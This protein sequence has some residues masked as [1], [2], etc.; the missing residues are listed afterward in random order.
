MSHCNWIIFILVLLLAA[1]AAPAPPPAAP[2]PITFAAPE[3][4]RAL[5][6]PLIAAFQAANPDLAVQFVGLDP[7]ASPADAA[8]RADAAALPPLAADDPARHQFL[9]LEPFLAADPAFGGELLYP[10]A[11]ARARADGRLVQLPAA[12]RVPLLGY[13]R[14]LWEAQGLAPRQGWTWSE[15]LAAAEALTLRQGATVTTAGLLDDS[16]GLRPLQGLLVEAEVV[17]DAPGTQLDQ[18][19]VRS[20]VEQVVTLLHNG[21]LHSL[22]PSTEVQISGDQ[23]AELILSGE[24]ATW[25]AEWLGTADARFPFGL[26]LTPGL[27]I[28][29][30]RSYVLSA[31][32]Q[33]PDAA[34]RW[35]SF[36]SQ[37]AD[38]P[39]GD[40]DLAGQVIPARR[41]LAETSPLWT[42]LD[43]ASAGELAAALNQTTP[44]AT[45]AAPVRAALR[46]ALDA[47][48]LE[49][50]TIEGA[51]LAAQGTLGPAASNNPA[52]T[53]TPPVVATPRPTPAPGIATIVFNS[54][55]MA[56]P[57]IDRVAQQ[58]MAANP[59]IVVRVEGDLTPVGGGIGLEALPMQADCFAWIAPPALDQTSL[60]LDLAPLM[61]ADAAF[62]Q[63]DLHAL[64][65]ARFQHNGATYALPHGLSLAA[66]AYHP[67]RFDALGLPYP[68]AAWTLNDLERAATQLTQG[69]GTGA[70][71]GFSGPE[72]ADLERFL[73]AGRIARYTGSGPTL[74]PDFTSPA[75]VDA[76]G[77]YINLV[78][79]TSPHRRL[80][81]YGPAHQLPR[82]EEDER[83]DSGSV[84]IWQ[85]S[86][87]PQI[88]DPTAPN[89][90]RPIAGMA[91]A[92]PLL[93][94]RVATKR[95]VSGSGLF[96]SARTEHPQACWRWIAFLSGTTAGLG[97]LA[98]ARASVGASE[99]FRTGANPE[100]LALYDAF[101]PLLEREPTPADQIEDWG[102]AFPDD[103][104]FYRAVDRAL[105][106]SGELEAELGAAEQT[107]TQ[108]LACAQTTGDPWRCLREADPQYGGWNQAPAAR[109]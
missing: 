53:P 20:A 42:R 108:Y 100:L 38:A 83:R 25:P 13:S 10:L 64:P 74:R 30:E 94:E 91:L 17:L 101:V 59:D 106:G 22:F 71:F 8:Q 40:V 85:S 5:Y 58:F 99:A 60:L 104:W 98:P 67:A 45:F 97:S 32:T 36:L 16:R 95:D 24:V 23:V 18:Q 84:A 103:F 14:D 51:L 6:D 69:R 44:P 75:M 93:A 72:A 82:E 107:T 29:L 28:E 54:W 109:P 37:R 34:W 46:Q 65:L 88:A 11:L 73:A 7:A 96:I 19:A 27:P 33:R 57:Q 41:V 55:A 63:D 50:Q 77:R 2:T 35:L 15:L 92:P 26:A 47:V 49:N 21:S 1:C 105:R 31:G 81:G 89:R 68:D 76:V 86:G 70:Q 90:T 66:L 39:A 52:P 62:P 102:R 78:Q 12:L 43:P 79:T 80:Y 61:D 56:D 87:L 9:D 3:A 48:L 4:E